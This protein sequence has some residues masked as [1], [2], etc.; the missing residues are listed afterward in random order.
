MWGLMLSVHSKANLEY[1]FFKVNAGSTALIVDWIVR[2][3]ADELWLRASLHS[4]ERRDV[5]FDKRP[6]PTMPDHLGINAQ[7][8]VGQVEDIRWELAID[9]G[10]EWIVPDI[11]PAKLLRMSDLTLSSAPLATFTGRIWH[12]GQCTELKQSPGMVSHYWG[13]RL[14]PE[15][16]W[17]SANQFEQENIAVECSIFRSGIWG[18][19]VRMPLAYLYLRQ[20]DERRLIM[21]PPARTQ[22]SGTPEQFE[23]RFQP[24]GGEP[25]T[26]RATGREY[27]DFGDGIINTL[28]GDLELYQG[29]RP[30]ARA[31]GT[32]ALERRAHPPKA[33]K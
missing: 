8:T 30:V 17:V 33:A 14:A 9:Y 11:F 22:V 7:Q 28:V 4:P 25:I 10:D 12:G 20:A 3:R 31:M 2:R 13:R 27:G 15:W 21:S 16:W 23:I 24:L 32:A 19:P 5:L 6:S 29:G 18:I 26:L 1:W